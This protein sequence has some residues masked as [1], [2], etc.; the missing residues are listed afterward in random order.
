MKHTPIL[1][2][3]VA[4]SLGMIPAA[5]GAYGLESQPGPD[6]FKE[7]ATNKMDSGSDQESTKMKRNPAEEQTVD[8]NAQVTIG[9]ARSVV[10]GEIRKVDDEY[11]F[12]KDDETGNEVRLL[13]NKDANLNCSAASIATAG[14]IASSA[15]IDRQPG[16]QQAPEASDRQKE[17]GQKK[18]QTA[19]GSGFRIGVC[20]FK[21]GDRIKAEV[22]DMGRVTTLKFMRTREEPQT[23]RSLGESAATGVLAI[24]GQQEKPGQLDM[25]GPHGYPPKEYAVPPIPQ[26]E[27]K[28]VSDDLLLHSSVMNAEGQVIGSVE[29]ILMDSQTGQIEYA[30]VLLDDSERLEVV[31]W[32]HMKKGPNEVKQEFVLDTT[33]YQ[34]SPSPGASKDR[35]LEVDKLL[36][37]TRANLRAERESPERT[38][39]KIEITMLDHGYEVKGHSLP[40]SL[41]AIV[42]RNQDTETHGISSPRFKELVIRAEG[43]ATEIQTEDIRSYHVPPGKTA[44]LYFTQNSHVDPLTG[45]QETI[46]YPFRCDLHPNM[47][48][49]FLIIET[50]GEIGGG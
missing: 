4:L 17:Q 18:D 35:S 39:F 8:H 7:Q 33:H 1:I 46:Q 31:P 42:L 32:T 40:D 3:S 22:D 9:G 6:P 37:D 2:A 50:R 29:N 45:Y 16:E 5:H 23:A 38:P 27:M 21:P 36:E 30:V 13:V 11:Y 26:G 24:P 20:S 15:A 10:S 47:K 28:S 25:T 19:V 12:I 49:E 14:A 43:D 48:G 34:L 41:T 44:T